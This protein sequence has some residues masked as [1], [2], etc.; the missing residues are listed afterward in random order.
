MSPLTLGMCLDCKKEK[1]ERLNEAPAAI[2]SLI[3]NTESKLCIAC[4]RFNDTL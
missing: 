1:K 3:I 2:H 4:D